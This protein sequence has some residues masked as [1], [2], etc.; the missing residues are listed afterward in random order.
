MK[1]TRPSADRERRITT[2]ALAMTPFL[3]LE[4]NTEQVP[5]ITTVS[6]PFDANQFVGG[7]NK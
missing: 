3:W 1:R 5:V 7:Y 4:K 2:I 6:N